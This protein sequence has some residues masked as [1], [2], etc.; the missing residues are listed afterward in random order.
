MVVGGNG[1]G[2]KCSRCSD[3][4]LVDFSAQKKSCP[5]PPNYPI[6]LAGA[7]GA[8]VAGHPV[9]CGG[10]SGERH[11][12]CY[13]HNNVTNKW[14]FLTNMTA[15]RSTSASV[16]LKNQL[17]VM[18]GFI[19][20]NK[21]L[22]STE[23]ISPIKFLSKPGPDLPS[24]QYRHCAVRLKSGK[25]MI[26]G[27]LPAENAKTVTV[28]DPDENTFDQSLPSMIHQRWNFGCAV[29]NSAMH[30]NRSIIL[31]AG[32]LNLETAEVYDYTQPNATWIESKIRVINSIID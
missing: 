29:F 26:I 8:I 4:Q 20:D 10:Y 3:V 7:T 9:I 31:A 6:A 27:G 12:E 2:N 13:I 25:V 16:Q 1:S 5:N 19:G 24:T 11:N 17:F 14:T 28:F 30:E 32:G 18:G 21:A 22:S 15:K 23:Y